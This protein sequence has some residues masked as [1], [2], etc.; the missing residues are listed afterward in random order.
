[1]LTKHIEKKLDGNCTRMLWGILHKFSKQNNTQQGSCKVTKSHLK[2]HPSKM[3]KI[4][5]ALLEKQ[6]QTHKQHSS[7][8]WTHGHTSVV[9]PAYLHYAVNVYS[10]EDLPEVM[11]DRNRSRESQG[12][13]CCQHDL[14]TMMSNN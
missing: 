5:E 10:L 12:S 7:M 2:N 13:S 1:M 8:N 3:N 6:G 11:D 9:W 4:C 14:M